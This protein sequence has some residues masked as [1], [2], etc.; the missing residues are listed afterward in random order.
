MLDFT[1]GK[2]PRSTGECIEKLE[3]FL[4][5]GDYFIA[6]NIVGHKGR[7]RFFTAAMYVSEAK[8]VLAFARSS[9]AA[10]DLRELIIAPAFVASP[11][12]VLLINEDAVALEYY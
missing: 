7:K 12:R 4:S 10:D 6:H 5:G 1:V 8:Y 2:T 11:S 3:A 9:T